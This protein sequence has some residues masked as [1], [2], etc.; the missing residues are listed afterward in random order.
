MSGSSISSN[1]IPSLSIVNK[2]ISDAQITLSGIGQSSISSGYVDLSSGQTIAGIKTFNGVCSFTNGVSASTFTGSLSGN[3]TTA[4]LAQTVNILTDNTAGTYY[5]PFLKSNVGSDSLFV[6]DVSVPILSYNPST[7]SL[8]S[9]SLLCSAGIT[10]AGLTSSNGL[11]VSSGNISLQSGIILPT[12]QTVLTIVAGVVTVNLNNLS[13]NEFILPSANFTSNITSFVFTN[14]IVNSKF[15][16]YIQ[17]A[18]NRTV[19]KNLGVG[20]VNTL[21]GNTQIASGSTW[22]VEG[23]VLSA[24]LTSLQWINFT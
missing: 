17:G 11:V 10:G 20:Q 22:R 15:Y 16:I 21:S 19:N 1:T 9:G 23:T 4:T 18:A 7:G 24:T 5:V 3:A 6:D 2:S 14:G 8:T 12:S 13:L